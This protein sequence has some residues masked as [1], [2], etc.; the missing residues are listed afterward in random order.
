MDALNS[1][2]VLYTI[3]HSNRPID[4]FI[5]MLAGAGIAR[6]VD[7]RALPKSRRWPQYD[8]E[9]LARSLA[10][11]GIEYVW[12]GDALGGFRKP[13]SDSPHVALRGSFRAFADHMASAQFGAAVDLLVSEARRNPV[14][15]MCAE[16]LPSECHRA[17][18][19]D[20]LVARR[21]EVVH[22]VAPGES[23]AGRL[24]PAARLVNGQLIYD[25][26]PQRRLL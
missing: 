17:L 22:L 21:I 14:A 26:V 7:V 16:R 18:I 13:S 23:E 4:A 19:A 11:H 9:A 1:T 10:A 6:L 20:Y 12:R 25:A 5:G 15:I 8:G 24:N 3:G 2:P